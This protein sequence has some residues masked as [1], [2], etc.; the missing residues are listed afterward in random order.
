[1]RTWGLC[2]G[3]VALESRKR[4]TRVGRK[5][6]VVHDTDNLLVVDR[7]NDGRKAQFQSGE[8]AKI[9]GYPKTHF[10]LCRADGPSSA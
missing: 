1:M 8:C 5:R 2:E 3:P 4:F 7:L 6:D 10:T 9:R